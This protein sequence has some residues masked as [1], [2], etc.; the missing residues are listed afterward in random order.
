MRKEKI[1]K[2]ARKEMDDIE[3]VAF[4]KIGSYLSQWIGKHYHLI[5]LHIT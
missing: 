5:T 2:K 1:Y 3:S 4:D